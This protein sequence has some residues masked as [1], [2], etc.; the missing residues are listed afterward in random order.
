MALLSPSILLLHISRPVH[1]SFAV[2]GEIRSLGV[3][4]HNISHKVNSLSLIK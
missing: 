1:D 2:P 3:S 4:K